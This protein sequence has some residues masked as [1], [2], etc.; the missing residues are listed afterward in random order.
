MLVKNRFLNVD[1]NKNLNV[2]C[3]KFFRHTIA[4]K[5]SN[6]IFHQHTG[7]WPTYTF[8]NTTTAKRQSLQA[9]DF[10]DV[11]LPSWLLLWLRQTKYGETRG[12]RG[13]AFKS[14]EYLRK[15][16][17]FFF[18]EDEAPRRASNHGPLHGNYGNNS[19]SQRET[20]NYT[21]TL[22]K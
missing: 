20:D 3:W 21:Q 6:I 18:T 17:N 11:T 9:E 19:Y 22:D 13:E 1:E 4:N 8:T 16:R 7:F 14:P 10:S 2:C 12:P 5:F 15:S